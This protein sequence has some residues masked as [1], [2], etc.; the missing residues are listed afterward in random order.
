MGKEGLRGTGFKTK[1]LLSFLFFSAFF[2]IAEGSQASELILKNIRINVHFSPDGG[3]TDAVI[4]EIVKAKSEVLVLAYSLSSQPIVKALLDAHHR[5]LTVKIIIDKSER[6]EGLTPAVILA[7]AGVPVLLD[8]KHFLAHSSCMIIDRQTVIT[9][10]FNYT[11][12]SEESNA[13]DLL[14]LRATRLASVYRDFWEKH[15]AHSEP[16]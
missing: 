11:R 4:K 14:I 6:G 10:S 8:G 5:G 12:A 15:R 13:E 7:N 3:A 9:G 1:F 16:D 2:P